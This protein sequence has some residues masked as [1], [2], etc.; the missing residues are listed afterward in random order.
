MIP[1]ASPE[2]G[3]EEQQRVA[4]VIESGYLADG[5]EVRDFEE[6]F[7][8]YCDAD[9]G[10]AT[11]NGTTAL[12]AAFEALDVGPGDRVATTPFSF[13][14][15]ANAIRL[16]GAEPVFLDIDPETYNLD[17][18]ALE[19][20]LRDGEEIDA[21]LAVHLY[22]L[23]AE[24]PRFVEL[25]D[26]YEF[27]LVEDAAQAHGARIDGQPV[28]SFGD[29]ACFSF[30]PTKNMTTG[31]GGMVVTNRRDVA[32]GV[33]EYINHGRSNAYGGSSSYEHVSVG[34]NFRLTSLGAAIGRA[35]LE[36][37]PRF[38]EARQQ[39]A[40]RLNVLLEESSVTTPYTPDGYEHSFHQ[41]TVRTD[42][43]DGLQET[44]DD[45]GVGSGI[46]YP[47]P[48]HQQQPYADLGHTAP[49]AETAATEAL[50]L[51][52]HPAL[53]AD[54]LE[55]IADAVLAHGEEVMA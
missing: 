11:S 9:H 53:S 23:P 26:E 28:G 14:A 5:P 41:Y 34:H 13:I 2:L 40:A 50:S 12:H 8:T 33:A 44:L 48:I 7:A 3:P 54:D 52:V 38:V 17:P 32:E 43:R 15:S 36:K 21:V 19:A 42:D 29:A 18:D 6:E 46:Y 24:M 35:Q 25:A 1:I 45:H 10:V 31:E 51:P 4:D 39:N 47:V 37:L 22:G 30:Y 16:T 20:A 55:V 49:N 27:A